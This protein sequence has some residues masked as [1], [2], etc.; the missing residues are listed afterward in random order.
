MN[1]KNKINKLIIFSFLFIF[2][3]CATSSSGIT[4]SNIPVVNRKYTVLGPVQNTETWYTFDVAIFGFPLDK[5]PIDKIVNRAISDKNA[6]ALI[7][8]KY[9][10]DKIIVLFI[11][12]NR[13]GIS[14]EAIKFEDDGTIKNVPKK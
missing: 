1:Y 7:N 8:I 13:I 4:T 3:H 6:D 11:T 5:P 2:V 12:V 9:W 10:Q 14:A